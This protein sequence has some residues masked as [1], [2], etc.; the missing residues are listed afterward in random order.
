MTMVLMLLVVGMLMYRS[1]D[2]NMWKWFATA[3]E[4][5]DKAPGPKRAEPADPEIAHPR[6][7]DRVEKQEIENE[8]SLV[9]DKTELGKLELPAYYRML[10]WSHRHSFEDLRQH[11]ATDVRF[12][13]IWAEPEKWRGQLVE[14][15]LHVRD[16]T[17]WDLE[18]PTEGVET[19]YEAIGWTEES[20]SNPYLVVFAELPEGMQIGSDIRE[21]ITFVGYFLKLMYY[22]SRDNK[23]RAA[24]LLIGRVI[25]HENVAANFR[26]AEDT[27]NRGEFWITIA[28]GGVLIVMMIISGSRIFRRRKPAAAA[29]GETPPEDAAA[30]DDWLINLPANGSDPSTPPE[31]QTG[32]PPDNPPAA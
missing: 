10:E 16:V 7:T 19:V 15:R 14:L 31:S 27:K 11:A 13:Q 3:P 22:K 1:A 21:E 30:M 25:R 28:V 17:Q 29:R 23:S 24:P 4:K 2:P 5:A 12:K 9:E 26:K 18:N 32:N 20:G 6:G 8:L